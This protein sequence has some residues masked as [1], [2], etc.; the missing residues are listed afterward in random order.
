M[1]LAAQIVLGLLTVAAVFLIARRSR[2]DGAVSALATKVDSLMILQERQAGHLADIERLMERRLSDV[3]ERL[4]AAM[5]DQTK[6]L[7]RAA[8]EQAERLGTMENR[9]SDRLADDAKATQATVRASEESISRAF[10]EQRM[11]LADRAA[12]LRR[13]VMQGVGDLNR[14]V[15]T[16]K[17][18]LVEGQAKIEQGIAREMKE[19][20]DLIDR[21]SEETRSLVDLRLKEIREA[22]DARLAEIQRA[23][24][25]QLHSAVEKQMNESFNRVIDQFAAVQKAMGDVQQVTSQIGDIKRIFSNVKTRGGWAEAQVKALLDDILPPGGYETNVRLKDDSQEAVEFAVLMP[26]QGGERVYLPIDAKFPT[27]DYERLL[28]ASEC[29]DAEGEARA[30]NALQRRVR[31]EAA[32]IAAKYIHPPRTVE[33]AVLYL[34]TEGLYAEVAR[35]NGLLE[36]L[37]RV[38][39]VLILGPSLLPA[40]LRTIQLGHV[41]LALNQKADL[42]RELLGATKTEMEKMDKVLGTLAKQVGTVGSTIEKAKVRTRAV[43]RKLKGIEAVPLDRVDE[44]LAIGAE[45]EPGEE[46]LEDEVAGG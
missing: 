41:T 17:T 8:T 44:I 29:G 11:Q 45:L 4:N 1:L 43:A 28:T 9:L 3:A 46:A 35:V 7:G 38:H 5:L 21:K 33:F 31:E 16:V 37:G 32:K 42:V 40:M 10:E 19:A 25:E 27:E 22:N 26:S 12:A 6:A 18:T 13:D 15:E 24:N 14:A 36:E 23:V 20:R 34:P 39:R 2:D 30:R